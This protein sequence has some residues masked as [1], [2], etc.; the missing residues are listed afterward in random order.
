MI[1]SHWLTLS[2][3]TF[4]ATPTSANSGMRTPH[5]GLSF[6]SG[7]TRSVFKEGD[8]SAQSEREILPLLQSFQKIQDHSSFQR[9]IRDTHA[10]EKQ[11]FAN[12]HQPKCPSP[13]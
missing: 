12:D 5:F 13:S 8:P 11:G 3:L 1:Y 6:R 2:I 4:V 10:L 9:L 7:P